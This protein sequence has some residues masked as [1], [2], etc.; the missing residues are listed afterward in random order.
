MARPEGVRVVRPDGTEV[1][2]E[3]VHD[4]PDDRGMDSWRVVGV[5][6]RPGLDRLQVAVFPA[7]T[8]LTFDV[9][10]VDRE[11]LLDEPS[12]D[13]VRVLRLLQE[14]GRANGEQLAERLGMT[15]DEVRNHLIELQR[16]GFI[17][18]TEDP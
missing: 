1:P 8:A 4:G 18:R 16:F 2:C 12:D 14:G 15:M 5:K 7:R 6:F 11:G 10:C 17:E 3:L 13:A 9:S